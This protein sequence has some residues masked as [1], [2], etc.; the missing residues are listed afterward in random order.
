MNSMWKARQR[1]AYDKMWRE[2]YRHRRRLRGESWYWIKLTDAAD[3]WRAWGPSALM[4]FI[5]VWCAAM[6][7]TTLF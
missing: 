7:V 4:L 2:A 3:F 5:V 1:S 6:V